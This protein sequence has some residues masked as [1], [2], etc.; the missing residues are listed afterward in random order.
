[1][2]PLHIL[3]LPIIWLTVNATPALAGS[4]LT[5]SSEFSKAATYGMNY[6]AYT[7]EKKNGKEA[8]EKLVAFDVLWDVMGKGEEVLLN[9]DPDA[10]PKF[11]DD[12][13]KIKLVLDK[14]AEV[15]AKLGAGENIDALIGS[16]DG[17]VGL[18]NH[19]VVNL[20]WE[21]VKLTYESHKLV[22][23]TKA[24]L[25]IETLYGIVNSDRRIMGANTG[26]QP[27]LIPMNGDT[28]TY[29][30]EKYLVTD[31]AT[32]A[33]VKTYV[34]KKLGEDFPEVSTGTWLWS[35]LILSE[36]EVQEEHEL[37]ELEEFKNNSRR[38]IMS[39]LDDLNTQVRKQWAETRLAQSQARFNAFYQQC[40]RAF[41]HLDDALAYFANLNRIKKDKGKYPG[42]LAALQADKAKAISKYGTIPAHDAVNRL[43]VRSALI[44][45][46]S[47]AN[48]YAAQMLM[49]SESRLEDQFRTLQ[50]ECM[51]FVDQIDKDVA[52]AESQVIQ[53]ADAAPPVINQ[54]DVMLVYMHQFFAGV[55]GRHAPN[56]H[57]FPKAPLSEIEGL[58]AQN[59]LAEAHDLL[60]A[61]QAE[62]GAAI[63]K[64]HEEFNKD[65]AAIQQKKPSPAAISAFWDSQYKWNPGNVVRL[66]DQAW[67]IAKGQAIA[68]W[69]AVYATVAN[70]FNDQSARGRAMIDFF[71]SQAKMIFDT[72]TTHLSAMNAIR[73]QVSPL[74]YHKWVIHYEE[75]LQENT[76]LAIGQI[77]DQDVI[78]ENIENF[79]SG[80]KHQIQYPMYQLQEMVKGM[81]ALE[82]Q[83]DTMRSI[84]QQ[85]RSFPHLEEE[86]LA[87]FNDL[88]N[89]GNEKGYTLLVKKGPWEKGPRVDPFWSKIDYKKLR[90]EMDTLVNELQPDSTL[91]RGRS[92]IRLAETDIANRQQDIDYLERMGQ[93][94]S[95]WYGRQKSN[96]VFARNNDGRYMLNFWHNPD[97][98]CAVVND[99]FRHCA[100]AGEL[101]QLPKVAQ[102]KNELAGLEVATFIA[103]S[104]PNANTLL[105]EIW[106]G[107]GFEMATEENLL[108]GTIMVEKSTLEKA[109]KMA[110][111]LDGTDANL[112][113]K[114]KKIGET[115]PF[116]VSFP[117]SDG[118]DNNK[119]SNQLQEKIGVMDTRL[120]GGQYAGFELG[121]RFLAVR[122]KVLEARL[123]KRD[124]LEKEHYE[125]RNTEDGRKRLAE[126]SAELSALSARAS[127]LAG[128]ALSQATA[129]ALNSDYWTLRTTY[130]KDK[131]AENAAFSAQL[132]AFD[133]VIIAL[134][135]QLEDKNQDDI[136]KVRDF[137]AAFKNAYDSK[138][139]AALMA[140]IADEWDSG[141]DTSF[142]DLEDYFGNMFAVF[143]TITYTVSDLSINKTG[144]NT[145][146]VTYQARITGTILD[147]GLTHQETSQ[148]HELVALKGDRLKIAK[149]L[150]GRFWYAE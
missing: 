136:N 59:H 84:T 118:K 123:A 10:F 61:W 45:A 120:I 9:G 74:Y 85:W 80:R 12:V 76:H 52:A 121:N 44:G 33:L 116:I 150:K 11:K 7:A 50:A 91:T 92:F 42:Y 21:A 26:D 138:S 100:V 109:E 143:D 122:K 54:T 114:L 132:R 60:L 37:R 82:A 27:A 113:G 20:L 101:E 4:L 98:N 64:A 15:S 137:Y 22:Q 24:E 147:S 1:M 81:G 96:G 2:K 87:R 110:A 142:A 66:G 41:D 78:L 40:G 70:E 3:I 31:S 6:A 141:G 146:E 32:R 89:T 72:V 128:A 30:Y 71:A 97:N 73:Q 126:Y 16:V 5:N 58:L 79:I 62:A 34:S 43:A 28:V 53:K 47:Q 127:S 29:F 117:K 125:A 130:F 67:D 8:A 17:M 99:P 18:V 135:K 107:K 95:I 108:V 55:V 14:V 46:A 105:A 77:N 65:L 106:A 133:N 68:G 35:K 112:S 38:W 103:T 48:A 148:V 139:E 129:E 140:L 51:K 88:A 90:G 75:F 86:T 102:A 124:L 19:P 131:Q 104:M 149:T 83:V 63:T 119:F 144:G 56:L 49:I 111:G 93:Q 115:L 23:S 25:E 145:Y 36:K 39:L 69:N 134:F 13:L 57:G 94:W